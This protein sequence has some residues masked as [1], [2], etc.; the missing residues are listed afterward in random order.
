MRH[1]P[2]GQTLAD[3]QHGIARIAVSFARSPCVQLCFQIGCGLGSKSRIARSDPR[4][5]FTVATG[6][7]LDSSVRIAL[8]VQLRNSAILF[9]RNCD[10]LNWDR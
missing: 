6:T 10:G 9:P 8:L 2:R 3:A 7:W 4:A 1:L 5:V